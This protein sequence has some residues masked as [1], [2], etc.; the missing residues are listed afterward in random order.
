MAKTHYRMRLKDVTIGGYKSIASDCPVQLSFNNINIL[1]GANGAGKSN[2][3]SFF[4]M[5]SYMMNKSFGVYVAKAGG[6]NSLLHYGVK[7]TQ[8]ISGRLVFSNDKSDD[9]YSFSLVYA[10]SD[11]LVVTEESLIWQRHGES[12]PY[13]VVLEYAV[14]ELWNKNVIGGRPL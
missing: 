4:T 11:R 1:L 7:N 6:A 5:L 3:I 9:V 10:A 14:S 2:I 12:H 8:T 13:Q